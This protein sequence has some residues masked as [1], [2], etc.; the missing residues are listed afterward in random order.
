MYKI[1]NHRIRIPIFVGIAICLLFVPIIS[2]G[3]NTFSPAAFS[4]TTSGFDTAA[5]RGISTRNSSGPEDIPAA[6]AGFL[7]G[8]ASAFQAQ[9]A[10]GLFR[11]F[12]NATQE[13]AIVHGVQVFV[14]GHA[15]GNSSAIEAIRAGATGNAEGPISFVRGLRTDTNGHA[16]GAGAQVETILARADGNAVGPDSLVRG[17]T[18]VSTGSANG[19]ESAVQSVRVSGSGNAVGANSRVSGVRV[20]MDGVATGPGAGIDA[21]QA[22]T[23][24]TFGPAVAVSATTASTSGRA[25]DARAEATSGA[26]VGVRGQTNS[27]QGIGIHGIANNDAG[28]AA[29]FDGR[30]QINCT[31]PPCLLVRGRGV[32]DLAENMVALGRVQPGDVVVIA[33]RHGSWGVARS[34][35]PYDT[36]VAGIVSTQP[37]ILLQAQGQR[38]APV[39]MVGII[40]AKA[41]ASNGPIRVGDLLTTSSI[42]G[43]LMRCSTPAKCIGAV[44]AKALQPLHRGNGRI[45]VLVWRQ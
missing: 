18:I 32:A 43:H 31:S 23:R 39:A 41:T 40:T 6:I 24:G 14:T 13:Q 36:R 44:V 38:T 12:G 35:R 37:R 45:S 7:T 3:H 25:V 17:A 2:A 21:V 34:T 22:H 33:T 1:V 15:Q 5:V 19:F 9:M 26:T 28:L 30:V 11:A 8:D 10:A 16:I 27:P 4:Q 29:R 42:P 20:T